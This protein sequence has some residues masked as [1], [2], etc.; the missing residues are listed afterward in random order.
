MLLSEAQNTFQGQAKR[1]PESEVN[2][3]S[4]FVEAER[5]RLLGHYEKAAQ[6]YRKFLE[7]NESESAAWYALARSLQAMDSLRG[8]SEA[9]AKAVA[10]DP[11]NI[12]YRILQ[13]DL[14]EKAGQPADAAKVYATLCRQFPEKVDFWERLAYLQVLAGQPREA[15]KTLDQIEKMIGL[16]EAIADKK[17]LIYLGLG[18]VKKAVAELQRLVHAYPKRTVY[19][20]R[21]AQVYESVGDKT[22]ARKVYEEILQVDPNDEKAKIALL[23]DNSSSSIGG[24]DLQQLKIVFEDP[25]ISIDNKVKL[26]LPYLKRMSERVFPSEVVAQLLHLGDLVEKIHPDDPKAWSLSG[27]LYYHANRY[28]EALARYRTCL[29][30]RPGV[31]SVWAN[32]LDILYRQG[33]IDELLR[34]SEN[35]MD[36][37]P[38]QPLAYYYYGLAAIAKGRP[39]DA[40]PPLEQAQLMTVG[41]SSLALDIADQIGRALLV[42]KDYA[43]AQQHYERVLSQG[44]QKHPGI[45]EHYGD[46]LFWQG[47]QPQAV[48]FWRKAAEIA[49]SPSLEQKIRSGRL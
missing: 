17:H 28:E 13:A 46:V 15:L 18:D 8:A 48:E 42:K 6:S 35:A 49:P 27:D 11:S 9:V 30:L 25:K 32:T 24:V 39:D 38:N 44:G 5:E 43:A 7:E 14:F 47:R 29:Q 40:I 31:F 1:I 19:R 34:L 20:H 2:R 12:W 41:S 4:A 16:T 37:F 10:L 33:D 26:V 22:A 23:T 45:L 3:Q 21:I 36:D